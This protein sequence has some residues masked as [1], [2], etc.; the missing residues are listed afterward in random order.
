[1]AYKHYGR[2][3][4]LAVSDGKNCPQ[5]SYDP[6]NFHFGPKCAGLPVGSRCGVRQGDGNAHLQDQSDASDGRLRWDGQKQCSI[7]LAQTAKHFSDYMV[8]AGKTPWSRIT[9]SGCSKRSSG[10]WP[11]T[12]RLSKA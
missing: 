3:G 4:W 7:H 12:T 2:D 1:M 5:H 8:Y 9:G 6:R 10:D 11:A